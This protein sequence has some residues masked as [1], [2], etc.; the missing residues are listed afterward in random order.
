MKMDMPT[1]VS[2]GSLLIA[3]ATILMTGRR[4]TRQSAADNARIGAQL[5]AIQTG[6]DDIR[7]EMR[8]VKEK[9]AGLSERMSVAESRISRIEEQLR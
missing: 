9:T 7:V 5:D 8:S 6:V 1:V 3:F 4:D 2:I